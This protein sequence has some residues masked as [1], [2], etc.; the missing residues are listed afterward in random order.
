MDGSVGKQ[1]LIIV[2]HLENEMVLAVIHGARAVDVIYNPLAVLEWKKLFRFFIYNIVDS[3]F[4]LEKRVKKSYE[5]GFA[6]FIA[7]DALESE[8]GFKAYELCLRNFAFHPAKIQNI[9][10]KG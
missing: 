6:L 8:V 9:F 5:N 7:K 3:E 1:L 2:L 10:G 4:F